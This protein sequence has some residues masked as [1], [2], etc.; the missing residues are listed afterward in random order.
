MYEP[1]PSEKE[2][3]AFGIKP[4]DLPE[5]VVEVLPD[6]WPAFQLFRALSTQ[7]RTGMAGATGL[8]YAAI[9]ITGDL[10]GMSTEEIRTAFE[11]IRIM[12]GEALDVMRPPAEQS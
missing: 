11:D 9:P 7:W 10:L 1:G 8:D 6:V 2:L 12:E 5:V 3:A 4:S